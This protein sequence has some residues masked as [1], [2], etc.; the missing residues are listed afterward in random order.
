MAFESPS[1]W[2]GIA[3]FDFHLDINALIALADPVNGR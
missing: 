1:A 3:G 2:P